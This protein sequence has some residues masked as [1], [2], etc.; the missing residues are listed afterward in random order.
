MSP[1]QLQYLALVRD[2]P[3][4]FVRQVH[5]SLFGRV[6]MDHWSLRSIV[7]HVEQCLAGR[8][9]GL[10]VNQ[11]PQHLNTFLAMVALPALVIA[12]DPAA[13]ILCIGQRRGGIQ[14][15]TEAFQRVIHSRW[16]RY[17]YP[18]VRWK[19]EDPYAME[20]AQ[21][22][23]RKVAVMSW[24]IA[25]SATTHVFLD[26]PQKL[27]DAVSDKAMATFNT[28]FEQSVLRKMDEDCSGGIVLATPRIHTRDLSQYLTRNPAILHLRFPA[29]AWERQHIRL[30]D[31]SVYCRYVG[32]VLN[33][34]HRSGLHWSSTQRK[35]G[36]EAYQAMYQQ[37]PGV[38]LPPCNLASEMAAWLS[39]N[40][41]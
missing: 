4:E 33:S 19:R 13:R 6:L 17:L 25:A 34:K 32:E 35:V 7:Y 31:T 1:D 12:R 28:L 29:V 41:S 2:D 18:Q 20:T 39:Q 40:A 21:G 22:G 24:D 27:R 9:P 3:F 36:S 16:F 14:V 38:R 30:S 15:A 10:V 23:V 11:P 8:V 5:Y 37:A 26:E